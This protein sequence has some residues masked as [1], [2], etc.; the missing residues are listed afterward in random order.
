MMRGGG[1]PTVTYSQIPG[2]TAMHD[3]RNCTHLCWSSRHTLCYPKQLESVL[4]HLALLV[5]WPSCPE[6]VL[7]PPAIQYTKVCG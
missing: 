4:G 1:S 2:L 3:T 5:V 7:C 6:H